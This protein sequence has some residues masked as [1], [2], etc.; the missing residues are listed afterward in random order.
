MKLLSY[1]LEANAYLI[2]FHLFYKLFLQKETFYNFNRAYLLGCTLLSFLL[3]LVKIGSLYTVKDLQYVVVASTTAVVENPLENNLM[4]VYIL[5]AAVML[6]RLMMRLFQIFKLAKRGEK[7]ELNGLSLVAIPKLNHAFSFMNR[8]FVSAELKDLQIILNHERVH[9]R[10]WHSLDILLMECLHIINW[11]NPLF[12][13][14][15]K[16]LKSLHEFI[17]D[18]EASKAESSVADYALYLIAYTHQIAPQ[19]LGNNMFNQSLLKTRIMKLQQK[20][21]PRI[22]RLKY[23]GLFL[24]LPAMLVLSSLSF[25]KSYSLVDLMP[26]QQDT[27]K[28]K[29]PPPPPPPA[30]TKVKGVEIKNIPPPPPPQEPNKKVKEMEIKSIPPPPPPV[31]PGKNV[32]GEKIKSILPPPPPPTVEPSKKVKGVEIKSIPPPPPPPVEPKSGNN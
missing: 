22:A 14:L 23:L 16:D 10:Q 8:L 24:L 3:P 2:V 11:F 7:S 32:N 18:A 31:E 4:L 12:I 28:K 9:I 1:F 27:I 29:T 20:K 19:N 5:V 17:A 21:S 13:I 6:L 25:A 26:V 30:P 15:K